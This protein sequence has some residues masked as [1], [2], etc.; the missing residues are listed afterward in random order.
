MTTKDINQSTK[1][2]MKYNELNFHE[3]DETL[4]IEI[5]IEIKTQIS[6]VLS[7]VK[8][9][10]DKLKISLI[11]P[12]IIENPRTLKEFLTGTE[13]EN[14]LQLVHEYRNKWKTES[15]EEPN[16][17]DYSHIQLID[18]FHENSNI[19]NKLPNW[20]DDIDSTEK[21]LLKLFEDIYQ[22]AQDRF[23]RSALSDLAKEKR[24]HEVYLT[25]EQVKKDIQETIHRIQNK[26]LNRLWKTAAKSGVIKKLED[27]LAFHQYE[28][29]LI[30]RKEFSKSQREIKMINNN[31]L[32]KQHE[33]GEEL[34]KA[35]LNYEQKLKKDL[36]QERHVRD[37][38]NKLQLQLQAL[39]TKYD[40]TLFDKYKEEILLQ[41]Q[42]EK[43][44]Q[45]LDLL[46]IEYEKEDAIYD[47]LVRTK[48]REAERLHQA[49]ILLFTQTHAVKIIQR[50]WRKYI[51]AQK[52]LRKKNAKKEKDKA[53][54]NDKKGDKAGKESD[55]NKGAKGKVTGKGKKK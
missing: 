53:N 4:N 17:N 45:E 50:Y 24:L 22:L 51:R 46:L 2:C 47:K 12:K 7:V 42:Y 29:S 52:L 28:S 49:K 9:A 30:I 39:I 15:S 48:V 40:Q 23:Y 6:N 34:N 55:E 25:N 37:E 27:E 19:L 10:I 54:K 1:K 31:S 18:Y 26:K 35:R 8:G 16:P 11:L 21:T 14:C 13:Y 44:K 33:L 5:P 32:S 3:I 43:E 41:E 36:I 20:L 38:R